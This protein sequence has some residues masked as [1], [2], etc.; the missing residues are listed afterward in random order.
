MAVVDVYSLRREKIAEIELK[1]EVFDVPMKGHVI[2]QVVVGQ[3]RNRRSGN[4]STKTRSEV[5][6][7][8][9]KLWRQKGTGRA[10][11]GTAASPTRRGGG[12]A[13]GPSPRDYSCKIPRKLRKAAL[14]MLLTDKR[15]IDRLFVIDQFD[16]P[17][18]KTK[19]FVEVMKNFDV[20]KALIVTEGSNENLEKSSRNVPWVKVM[21]HEGLNA[22]DVLYYD[23]LF[24][25]QSAARKIEEALIS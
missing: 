14:R 13:F 20:N 10:R 1:D 7:S 4:A 24:L 6:A 11:V 3:L 18:M 2:H 22:Y 12:V 25:S 17:D 19:N 9:R 16:L 15:Q 5:R 23:Y 8:G 21:R